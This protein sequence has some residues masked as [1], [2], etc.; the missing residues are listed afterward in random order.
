MSKK[1]FT[2]FNIVAYDPSNGE[3][4]V[5]LNHDNENLA[6]IAKL[7]AA[8]VHYKWSMDWPTV[9]DNDD[10]LIVMPYDLK[11]QIIDWHNEYSGGALLINGL[12]EAA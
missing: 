2:N 9:G 7:S 3:Q 11:D 6:L 1:E 5:E 12:E 10:Y 8:E 4:S